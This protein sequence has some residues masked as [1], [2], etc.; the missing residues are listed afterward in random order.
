MAPIPTRGRTLIELVERD[1]E[2]EATQLDVD[3]VGTGETP[4]QATIDYCEQLEENSQA[5]S[6]NHPTLTRSSDV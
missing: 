1:G 2:W 6:A 5:A 3:V 4:I